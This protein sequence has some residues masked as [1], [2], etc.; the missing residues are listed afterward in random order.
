MKTKLTIWLCLIA[1]VAGVNAFAQENRLSF[2]INEDKKEEISEIVEINLAKD[3]LYSNAQEWITKTFGDYKSVIQLE[4]PSNGKLIIKGNS[5]IKYV[6]QGSL[7]ATKEKM[8][9]AITIDCRDN[10]Y[11]YAI[12]DIEITQTFSVLGVLSDLKKTHNSHLESMDKYERDRQISQT[13][14]DSLLAI[15]VEKFKKKER[16]EVE[17]KI[18]KQQKSIE[19]TKKFI[20]D[21]YGFCKEEYDIMQLIISTL[22][23]SMAKNDDF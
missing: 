22:K 21:S 17:G 5:K 19:N 8:N 3:K 1:Q 13:I 4:D 18:A 9:Y 10:K 15:N 14:L 12:S 11:R 7:G 20:V 23:K 6:A 16:Q 2:P